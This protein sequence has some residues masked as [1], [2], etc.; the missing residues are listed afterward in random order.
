[1]KKEVDVDPKPNDKDETPKSND[2]T[3]SSLSLNDERIENEDI[4]D[5]N[6]DE[7]KIL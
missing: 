7:Q 5:S 3:L 6:G 4:C 1:M 2:T